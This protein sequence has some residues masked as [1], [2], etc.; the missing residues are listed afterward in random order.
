MTAK[1]PLLV[2]YAVAGLALALWP[3]A[4]RRARA[5]P[6]AD[7][8]SPPAV[9]VAG[10]AAGLLASAV[11]PWWR[12]TGSLLPA[13]SPAELAFAIAVAAAVCGVMMQAGAASRSRAPVWV[14]G[15]AAALLASTTLP[16][17]HPEVQQ[18][19]WHHWGAYIGPS[20][21]LLAGARLFSDFPPQYGLGPTLLVAAGCGDSCWTWMHASVAVLTLLFAACIAWLAL[22]AARGATT[23]QRALALLVCLACC[24]FWDAFPP[25]LGSPTMT[26]S[27]NGMRFLPALVLACLLV[28]WDRDD[29]PFPVLAGHAAWA[30]ACL[31]SIE[32]AFYATCLWWPHYLLLQQA[33]ASASMQTL[34]RSARVLVVLLAAWLAA[35]LVGTRLLAGGWPTVN[36]LLAYIANPPGALPASPAGAAWFFVAAMVPGVAANARAFAQQGNA[37]QARRGLV[38]LLLAYATFSYFLGRS[39]DNNILNLLPFLAV[40]LLYAWSNL[41]GFGRGA[42]AGMFAGLLAWTLTFNWAP[43]QAGLAGGP[44]FDWNWHRQVLP[45]IDPA[46]NAFPAATQRVIARAQALQRDP[47]TVLGPYANPSSPSATAV[48]SALHSPA[49]IS[50]LDPAVRRDFLSRTAATLQ[51]SGWLLVQASLPPAMALVAD[52]DAVYRRTRQFEMDG[53]LAIHY[54][55]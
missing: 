53:Y 2:A 19:A 27:V 24:F 15:A 1:L 7:A 18:T 9:L 29:R 14:F 43:W 16:Y 54:A 38:L 46:R 49:N 33:S 6:V 48:W 26:P 28:A 13:V 36:G 20:E 10:A 30:A 25:M 21:L 55:P 52:F 23:R 47:V 51:R 40:V 42:S 31:W 17:S 3:L 41:R 35:F 11:L 44:W 5:A 45:S 22:H 8:L 34:W 32:S 4:L 39:H 12:R 37:P 50:V